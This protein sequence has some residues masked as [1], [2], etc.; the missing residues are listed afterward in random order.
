MT[1]KVQNSHRCL[2]AD[3]KKQIEAAPN[4]TTILI[5]FDETLFLRNSTEEYLRTIQPRFLGAIVLI[6]LDYLKPWFWLLPTAKG[7][8]LRD[9]LRVVILT[10]LFPWTLLLWRWKVKKLA[11]QYTN[12]ELLEA[13]AQ[14]PDAEVIVASSGFSAIVLPLL[15]QMSLRSARLISCRFWQGFVDRQQDKLD[16]VEAAIGKEKLKDAIA[17]TD[18]HDDDSLLDAVALP[19]LVIWPKAKFVAATADIY[20]PFVY[21][22]KAKRP[23]EKFFVRVVLA[24]ELIVAI[25]ATTWL[26]SMPIG[27]A[28]GIL[29]FILSFWCIYELGYYENDLIAE[30]YEK[31]PVLSKTY[32]RYKNRINFR[33]PWLWAISFAVPGTILLHATEFNPNS[34][35]FGFSWW[36]IAWSGML[37]LSLLVSV[38]IT[39]LIYNHIDKQTRVWIF[40]LLQIY[41]C[42]GLLCVT[43]TNIVGA[44]LFAAQVISRWIAYIVYRYGDRSWPKKIPVQLLRCLLFSFLLVVVAV[45][46]GNFNVLFNWQTLVIFCWCAWRSRHQFKFAIG[47]IEIFRQ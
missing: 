44:S 3:F 25:L 27:H 2:I 8:E 40:P 39:Y 26:S 46:K 11:R 5:D 4:R 18:S 13:I 19:C 22:E 10:L 6:L 20:F 23:G 15:K 35:A 21:L 47:E 34:I 1:A 9:W 28:L 7:V 14:K 32:K 45:G 41:K 42:F 33:E 43:T 30:K 16:L 24:D 12:K 17:I 37:W 36:K 29:F 31:D 38:R